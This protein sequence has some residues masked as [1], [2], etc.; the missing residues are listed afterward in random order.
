LIFKKLKNKRKGDVM[1]CITII[2]ALL[3]SLFL[4][5]CAQNFSGV[6]KTEQSPATKLF[7]HNLGLKKEI[8]IENPEP[9]KTDWGYLCTLQ[10]KERPG[11]D[12]D[13]KEDSTFIDIF[14]NAFL[15]FKPNGKIQQPFTFILEVWYY[16]PA[17]K[18][19]LCLQWTAFFEATGKCSTIRFKKLTKTMDGDILGEKSSVLSKKDIQVLEPEFK[20]LMARILKKEKR[21]KR[22]RKKGPPV[23]K[24]PKYKI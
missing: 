18:V 19:K 8:P 21:E 23:S 22:E 7:P 15:G 6:K 5:F 11:K 3:L 4:C 12:S 1:R 20:D 24:K 17:E 13:V 16:K 14:L 9:L 2:P 10:Y